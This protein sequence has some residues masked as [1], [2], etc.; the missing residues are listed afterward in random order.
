MTKLSDEN[1]AVLLDLGDV[2]K[3]VLLALFGGDMF[4]TIPEIAKQFGFGFDTVRKA[5]EELSSKKL[6][7]NS[8]DKE[9]WGLTLE[10]Q[11][12]LD[13]YRGKGLRRVIIR[14]SG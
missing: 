10:G 8:T 4:H 2:N 12:L 6:A 9:K 7:F 3:A 5:L 14:R 11:A 1:K 13:H